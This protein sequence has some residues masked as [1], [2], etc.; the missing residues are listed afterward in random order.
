MTALIRPFITL[1]TDFGL[2]DHF[3]GTMKGV[4]ININP[5]VKI[6]DI[7]HQ[8]SP[9]NIEEAAFVLE[10]AYK[11][12][13]PYTIHVVVVDP[14]VGSSRKPLLVV[15]DRYYFI[16]PDNGAL[17]FLFNNE[18]EQVKV[19]E[20]NAEHYFLESPGFTFHGRDIFAPVAAWLSKGI[21]VNNFGIETSNYIRRDLPKAEIF[22]TDLIRGKVIH[23]DKFGNL[24]SNIKRRHIDE[25]V[26]KTGKGKFEIHIKKAKIEGINQ[27]YAQGERG[28]PNAVINSNGYIEIY[29][30][31]G[32]AREELKAA[33]G[34]EV[35]VV[36]KK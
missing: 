30:Y 17:S 3:V 36:I 16:T 12:F 21:D 29:C 5:A 27:F 11:Y 2:S 13:P 9:Q 23:I 31:M 35:G 28:K 14:E 34:E 26:A 15:G 6:I 1:T 24:I 32:N 19:I 4:I 33:K 10:C 25:L 20:I 8:I 18:E 7:S 22:G